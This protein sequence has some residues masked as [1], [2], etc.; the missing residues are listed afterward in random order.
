MLL[1]KA[2]I[3]MLFCG[4]SPTA[5]AQV[6]FVIESLPKNTPKDDTVFIT[7]SFNGWQVNDPDYMLQKQ[8]DGRLAI[9]LPVVNDRPLEYKFT[10]GSWLKVETSSQNLYTTNR[11]HHPN[12]SLEEKVHV[13][14]ANWL[15]LGGAETTPFTVFYYFAV[16]IQGIFLLLLGYR[17]SRKSPF[18]YRLFVIVNGL[19][20][21]VFAGQV[22]YRFAG[23]VFQAYL[24]FFLNIAFF[25]WG[26]GLWVY[27]RGYER[28][29]WPSRVYL[30]FLPLLLMAVFGGVMMFAS[31]ILP[32]FAA[33]TQP[34][35]PVGY[36]LS[37][38]VGVLLNL[39]YLVMLYPRWARK[40]SMESKFANQDSF[41]NW[42]LRLQALTFAVLLV[43][44]LLL[45][46]GNSSRFMMEFEMVFITLSATV[47]F[48]LVFIWRYPELLREKGHHLPVEN[49]EVFVRQINTFMNEEK[50]YKNPDL[51]IEML[52]RA[53]EMKPHVL[54]RI[55]NECFHKNF[56]DFVNGYR[57]AAF[58]H[59]AESG[60]L[61]A[62][63]YLALAHEVGFN[64]KSTFNL[65]FKK[66]TGQSPREYLNQREI[67]AGDSGN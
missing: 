65:A 21:L 11:Y 40:S 36:A 23:F 54:S 10:R 30:H 62:Y 12:P 39:G 20:L 17:V 59:L 27:V 50:P 60:K 13:H 61:G 15:D 16:A 67:M 6:T 44:L 1:R 7:G 8:P 57:V 22:V 37:F 31:D 66:V 4:V 18:K 43:N 51:N 29:V 28:G 25:A 52:A 49:E 48:Q 55:L 34:Y 5:T 53:L 63:T 38:G 47:F 45:Y 14:I 24:V 64:S 3:V 35:F 56:R 2:L 46:G 32:G 41:V 26:P 33:A 58:V 42:F 19:L 9:T